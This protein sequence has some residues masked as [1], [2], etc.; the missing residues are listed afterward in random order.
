MKQYGAQLLILILRFSLVLT[1]SDQDGEFCNID[2]PCDSRDQNKLDD[3]HHMYRKIDNQPTLA[4]QERK[5]FRAAVLEFDRHD[6]GDCKSSAKDNLDRLERAT[7]L[8]AKNG[9][10]M[11]VTPEDGIIQPLSRAFITP[12]LEEIPDPEDLSDKNP[13]LQV[14]SFKSYEILRRL[15]CIARENN[16]YVIANYGSKETCDTSPNKAGD[17]AQ[18]CPKD[19]IM[20]YNTDVIFDNQ[21][22]YIKRYRKWNPFVEV[23]DKAPLLEHTY[24]DTSFG[25]FGIFTCFDILFKSPAIDLVEK[26][27]IDAAIFPTLWYDELPLL[28]AIQIQDG[29]SWTNRVDMLASNILRPQ[30]GTTGSGIFSGLDT[31]YVGAGNKKSRLILANLRPRAGHQNHSCCEAGFEPQI[32][33][34]EEK[35]LHDDYQNKDYDLFDTDKIAKF[36]KL[37]DEQTICSGEVCCSVDY[38]LEAKTPA[39]LTSRIILIARDARRRGYFRWHEQVCT[40]ATIKDSTDGPEGTSKVTFNSD[41]LVAF[42]RLSL[43]AT[44]NTKYVYPISAHKASHLL[45]RTKRKFECDEVGSTPQDNSKQYYCQ[46]DLLNREE[47]TRLYSF[48]MYGRPYDSDAIPMAAVPE[49]VLSAL[50]TN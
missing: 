27:N 15:S 24:F 11:I 50:G 34:L 1:D 26:Y 13:C 17:S 38:E 47:P 41:A 45:E 43:S 42:K 6:L 37:A 8:A 33:D 9:A 7:Q 23:F 35:V 20:P 18:D 36:D 28:T 14:E 5:C 46:I 31:V 30:A 19:G 39:E 2:Q 12:C 48:G 49:S 44:F 29:W 3:R 4:E 16:I 32:L 22:N 21:G 25:R 40:L 10:H